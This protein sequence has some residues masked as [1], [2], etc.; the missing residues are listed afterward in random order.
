MEEEGFCNQSSLD[1]LRPLHMST[2]AQEIGTI[3]QFTS[4]A[5][6]LSELKL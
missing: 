1:T 6:C 5:H 3:G 4:K 2:T